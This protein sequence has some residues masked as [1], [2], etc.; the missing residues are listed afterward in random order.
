MQPTRR[1]ALTTASLGL[2]AFARPVKA[3]TAWTPAE[4]ANVDAVTAFCAAWPS[5]DITRI[6]SF[7]AEQCSYRL[8]ETREP[9]K[10]RDAVKAQIA[11][12]VDSVREFKVLETLA[13]GPMVF[14]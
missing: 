10:G 7:F 2:A 4:K 8:T 3:A 5:H 6:M 12:I 13:K 9:A 14:N 1:K 11:S